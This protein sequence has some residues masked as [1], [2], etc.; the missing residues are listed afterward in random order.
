MSD[1]VVTHICWFSHAKAQTMDLGYMLL[2]N[3]GEGRHLHGN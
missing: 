1:L 3:V 2:F